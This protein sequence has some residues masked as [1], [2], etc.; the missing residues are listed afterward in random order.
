LLR[1]TTALTLRQTPAGSP[2]RVMPTGEIVDLLEFG[3]MAALNGINYTWIR[4]SA[5]NDIGWCAAA[6]TSGPTVRLLG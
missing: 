1:L 3:P 2:I 4:V 5:G 6:I